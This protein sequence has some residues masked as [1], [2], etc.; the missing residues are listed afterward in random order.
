MPGRRKKMAEDKVKRVP[1]L[2]KDLTIHPLVKLTVAEGEKGEMS[3]DFTTLPDD[4]QGKLG[5]FGLGH[6]LGDAAAGRKGVDAEEAI[7][8]VWDGLMAANWSVR[9]PAAPKVSV[10]QI[11]DN[12]AKL[13]GK[14]KAVAASLLKGLNITVPGME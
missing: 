13:S 14:D 9:A 3:F 5:P 1:K 4:I 10:A 11:A 7:Q 8:K 6:K 2:K 12:F